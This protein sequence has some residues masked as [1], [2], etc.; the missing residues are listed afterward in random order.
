MGDPAVYNPDCFR[1]LGMYG[2][3]IVKKTDGTELLIPFEDQLYFE[4]LP[5]KNTG[6]V[7]L[8]FYRFAAL[9]GPC[10]GNLTP[11]QEV[12]SGFDN[13][14]FNGDY[15]GYIPL[16]VSKTNSVSLGKAA[17]KSLLTTPLPDTLTYTLSFSNDGPIDVGSP[18]LGLPFIIQDSIPTGTSY[19]AGSASA[20]NNLPAGVGSYIILYS[21]DNAATWVN[22][23][24]TA[25]S[26][27]D[28]RW[29]L[30]DAL[31][32]GEMG[33]VSFKIEI[34]PSYGSPTICNTGFSSFGGA[35]SIAEA[36][37]C[38]L[39]P[40]IN[41]IGDTIWEDDGGTTGAIGNGI[42]E[43]DEA[44]IPNIPVVL[45][46]DKN[47]DGAID[48]GDILWGRDTTDASGNYLFDELPDGNY[49]VQMEKTDVT[50]MTAYTG[51]GA[52]TVR[53]FKINN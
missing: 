34:G 30:S 42:Q 8:V 11:Y 21:T 15:G 29:L 18:A 23:E 33:D 9:D 4:N 28:I 17:D 14:K 26:V 36:T 5:E 6:A 52:T 19:L 51:W 39:L 2:L 7:G 12:A 25:S 32:A 48:D 31:P 46:Y 35:K 10:A 49:I 45:Y 47:G 50:S 44:G 20:S 24:P 1:L 53:Q 41:S 40:G 27:T 3:V 37:E 38:S 22:I 16:A 13:E 43:G